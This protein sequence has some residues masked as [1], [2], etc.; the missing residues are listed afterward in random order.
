MRSWVSSAYFFFAGRPRFSESPCFFRWFV[1]V[2]RADAELRGDLLP[3]HRLAHLGEFVLRDGHLPTS[4]ATVVRGAA[5]G[6]AWLPIARTTGS[7]A[8]RAARATGEAPFSQ[9]NF[10]WGA[11]LLQD[12]VWDP[13]T[14][15]A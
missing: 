11:R 10:A 5:R 4:A 8:S 14:L 2:P 3:R 9:R 15:P 13:T 12:A 6:A 1:T 7:F